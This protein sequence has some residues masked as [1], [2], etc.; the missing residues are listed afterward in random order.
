PDPGQGNGGLQPFTIAGNVGGPLQPGVP[1]PVDLQITNP[2]TSPLVIT[3]LTASVAAV[4]APGATP[5]LPCT[6][7]DFSMQAFSGPLPLTVPASS[8]RR[9]AELGVP[10]A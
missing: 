3:D 8:T 7:S 1:Q 4:S 6:L 9:L 5:S 10:A 2:N